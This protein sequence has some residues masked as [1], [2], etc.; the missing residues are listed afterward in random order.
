MQLSGR[1]AAIAALVPAGT[2]L[3]DIGT[4]H[5]RVPVALVRSGRI[6]RAIASDRRPGPLAAAARTIRAAGVQDRVTL[7]LADGLSAV[8][9]GE[10]GTLVLAGMGAETLAAILLAPLPAGVTLAILQP[11][12]RVARLRATL[13]ERGWTPVC[14][15][16]VHERGRRYPILVVRPPPAPRAPGP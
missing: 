14:E 2:T 15:D 8:A 1:L 6:P 13:V 12:T 10:A 7:R 3:A 5:A 9:P 4:D 16:L 11:A